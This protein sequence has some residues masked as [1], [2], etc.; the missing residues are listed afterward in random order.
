M[1][2]VKITSA[3]ELELVH[4]DALGAP[5]SVAGKTTAGCWDIDRTPGAYPASPPDRV[6]I[7]R[8]DAVSLDAIALCAH[9]EVSA[10]TCL[11]VSPTRVPTTAR[12]RAAVPATTN[13]FLLGR[14]P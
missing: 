3:A 5:V 6:T 8:R 4:S 12:S 1:T 9:G 14:A 10:W 13:P 11:R 7:V 2:P